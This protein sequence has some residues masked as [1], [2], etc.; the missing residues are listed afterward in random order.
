[1]LRIIL[2]ECHQCGFDQSE[3]SLKTVDV[4][5][6]EVERLIAEYP[7]YTIIGAEVV[8]RQQV[9]SPATDVQQPKGS[10]CPFFKHG[11]K[12]FSEMTTLKCFDKPCVNQRAN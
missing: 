4:Q 12:C 8:A 5:L 2:R 1:M 6:P 3:F 11:E 7:H 9:E 10:I